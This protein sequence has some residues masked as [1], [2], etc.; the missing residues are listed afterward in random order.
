MIQ[1]N[2]VLTLINSEQN[3]SGCLPT[4]NELAG[5]TYNNF[6]LDGTEFLLCSSQ[7]CIGLAQSLTFGLH[8]AMNL[9]KFDNI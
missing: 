6:G 5:P 7:L 1:V 4:H 2:K 9:I 3:G 8:F